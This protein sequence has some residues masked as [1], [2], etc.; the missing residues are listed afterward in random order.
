MKLL[1]IHTMISLKDE[2]DKKTSYNRSD[3]SQSSL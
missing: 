1:T 3:G 2:E